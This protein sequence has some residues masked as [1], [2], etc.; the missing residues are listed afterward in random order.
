MVM[1]RLVIGLTKFVGKQQ[2]KCVGFGDINKK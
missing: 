2:Y 1:Y